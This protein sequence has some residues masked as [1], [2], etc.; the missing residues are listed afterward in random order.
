MSDPDRG[1]Y[2]PPTDAPL[3]FDARRPSGGGGR[4]VPFTLILSLLVL[5]AMI[6]AIFW[7]YRGGVRGEGDAP[8]PVGTPFGQITAPA[9]A[10]A[11]PADP[12]AGL[13]IYK[14]DDLAAPDAPTFAPPP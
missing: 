10:E 1:A 6:A 2:T 3:A 8:Q 11:Q 7:F 14:A 4:P 13:E 12:A 5:A 9:P